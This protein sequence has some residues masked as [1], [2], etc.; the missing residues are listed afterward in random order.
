[1]KHSA[2]QP[3]PGPEASLG[4]A[5]GKSRIP[6]IPVLRRLM[7]VAAMAALIAGVWAGLL[8]FGLAWP[9]L[10][11]L[12]PMTHGPLMVGGFLGALISLERAVAL[13]RAWTY[14]APAAAAI[15][16]LLATIYPLQWAGPLLI[17]VGSALLVVIMAKLWRLHPTL[18]GGVLVSG[19]VAWLGGNLLWLSG[20]SIPNVVMWWAG[21]MILTIAGERLELSRMLRLTTTVQRLFL[22]AAL[23]F[24]LGLAISAA[25]LALGVRI[26]GA[27]MI[28]LA[29]WLLRYDIAWRR[30]HAGGQA[31]FVAICLLSGYA[32][33][34]V[35]GLLALRYG[36]VS[37]GM[38]Y[39]AML[40]SIFLG[41]VFA[42]IF[43]HALIVFPAI[44]QIRLDYRPRFYIHLALL[45]VTL[46]LR[47]AGDLL[48]NPSLRTWSGVL[49]A[50]VLLLFLL[51]T[52]AAVWQTRAGAM[53]AA[54]AAKER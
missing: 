20:Y 5:R 42:M 2:E 17:A 30:L 44:L 36:G 22:A 29:A 1:M 49:N 45:H 40:H 11:R 19:A 24:G 47:V 52:A 41:F 46:A 28:A 54:G 15:G 4:R 21:F 8:R 9:T 50:V 39:D 51:S 16:A 25:D 34:V 3:V 53:A 27:G 43:G 37:A 35:G 38:A 31:R 48:V 10:P 6:V 14:A 18:Y 33:L 32:W 13:N 23:L 26:A 12:L 7:L